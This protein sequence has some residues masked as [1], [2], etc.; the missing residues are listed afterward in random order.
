MLYTVKPGDTLSK[1]SSQFNVP[2]NAI[3]YANQITTPDRIRVGQQI[4]LPDETNNPFSVLVDTKKNQL[5][6]KV[7]NK[8]VKTYSVATGK[9]ATPSPKGN[10]KIIKKGLWGGVFGGF[11]MEI[12]VP[13][14]IYGIHGT[15]KPWSIGKSVSNGCI[16]MYS[17]QA[18]ELYYMLPIGTLVEII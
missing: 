1:I 6:L 5:K 4:I 9:P 10:W 3:I 7:N 18:R 13:H 2:L 14:G 17:N 11:F 8:E 12:D 15:D 16:R